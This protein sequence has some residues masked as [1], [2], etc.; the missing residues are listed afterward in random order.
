MALVSLE[1]LPTN[2][3]EAVNLC[4]SYMR[5]APIDDLALI[6]TSFAA[7]TAYRT[8]I[9]QTRAL[10]RKDFVFNAGDR[11]YTPVLDVA[12]GEYRILADQFC[13]KVVGDRF[14]IRDSSQPVP[15]IMSFDDD[16]DLGPR[17]FIVNAR[18]MAGKPRDWK[19]ANP[20]KVHAT[21]T[22]P[23]DFLPE[24]AKAVVALTAAALCGEHSGEGIEASPYHAN[25]LQN[26]VIDLA[27]FDLDTM[28]VNFYTTLDNR[29]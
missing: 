17:Q 24:A 6:N 11:S 18:D 13:T 23:F 27:D 4:L 22:M 2:L 15:M 25:E 1:T 21:F 10:Q 14:A 26:A 5:E 29:R 12:S 9:Q 7:E 19:S 8:V 28:P 16:D 3:L 20:V